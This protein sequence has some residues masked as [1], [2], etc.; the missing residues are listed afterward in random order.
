M[1]GGRGEGVHAA[2]ETGHAL[3]WDSC[4]ACSLP[5][6]V[7]NTWQDTCKSTT[8]HKNIEVRLHTHSWDG[9]KN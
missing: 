7:N 9:I 2:V 4:E 1:K 3:P 8:G 5:A 6:S